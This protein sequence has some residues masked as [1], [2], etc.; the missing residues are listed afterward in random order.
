MINISFPSIKID[1][2]FIIKKIAAYDIL[3]S[4]NIWE[5]KYFEFL[6][7]NNNDK[8]FINK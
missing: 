6:K 2:L 5:S 3:D 7:F 8:P 1:I 4:Y